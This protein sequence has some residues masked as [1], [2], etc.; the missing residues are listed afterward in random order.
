MSITPLTF[1]A[2][3]Q[4]PT[5]KL[6][7]IFPL[8]VAISAVSALIRYIKPSTPSHL[9]PTVV[10]IL[11]RTTCRRRDVCSRRLHVHIR[12][13]DITDMIDLDLALVDV[14]RQR[15]EVV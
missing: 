7:R 8:P 10:P 12:K 4:S 5:S 2:S 9:R 14:H 3:N 6:P 15:T 1:L 11:S 13:A